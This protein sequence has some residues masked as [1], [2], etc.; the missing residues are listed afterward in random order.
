[1]LDWSVRTAGD[2]MA[3]AASIRTV[4]RDIDST[5]PVT[6]VQT[7]DD[8]RS[9]ATASQ[10]FN[11]MLIGVFAVLALVLAA[12]GVYGVTAYSVTQRTR[13]LGIRVAL[14]ARRGE[15]LRLVLG[16]GARL[17]VAGLL[18]GV[19]A[20]LALT[21]L[22]AT[23]LFRVGERDPLTF[24]GVC[25]VLLVVSLLASLIPACRATRVDP[26]VALRS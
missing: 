5:L 24:L 25:A 23:M 19:A 16:H 10:Q 2:P 1:M 14:G 7:M 9:S 12:V 3:L 15:L 11:L 18:V 6:R 4:I 26:V 22:M 13:E 20:A 8:I 21:R 17:A